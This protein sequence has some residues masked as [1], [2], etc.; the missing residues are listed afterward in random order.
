MVLVVGLREQGNTWLLY[1]QP[2]SD[3]VVRLTLWTL[4]NGDLDGLV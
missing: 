3:E 4:N 1:A 2:L